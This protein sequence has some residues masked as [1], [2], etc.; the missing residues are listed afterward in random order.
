MLPSSDS[1][2]SSGPYP[3]PGTEPDANSNVEPSYDRGLQ[4]LVDQA[5]ADLAERLDVDPES[6]SIGSAVLVTWSD[7]GFLG[8]AAQFRQTQVP[9]DGSEIILHCES[10][11][12]TGPY[13][14]RTGGS[15]YRPTLYL[16]DHNR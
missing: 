2:P 4:P 5:I 3:E 6:I 16:D 13:R 15:V 12:S 10:H 1:D 8:P 11:D 7:R 9:I 14:Y